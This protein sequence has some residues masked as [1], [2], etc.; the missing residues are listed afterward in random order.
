MC[1]S[2]RMFNSV[3]VSLSLQNDTE[4]HS[5]DPGSNLCPCALLSSLAVPSSIISLPL[6]RVC[7]FHLSFLNVEFGGSASQYGI[8]PLESCS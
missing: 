5:L 6:L 8:S 1:V 7:D 2:D 3:L 4:C